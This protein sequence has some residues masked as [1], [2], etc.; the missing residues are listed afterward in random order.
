MHVFIHVWGAVKGNL[1]WL[2]EACFGDPVEN[3]TRDRIKDSL[4]CGNHPMPPLSLPS[5]LFGLG[6][7]WAAPGVPTLFSAL[8]RCPASSGM[9]KTENLLSLASGGPETSDCPLSTPW[10]AGFRDFSQPDTH[11]GP[12][13]KHARPEHPTSGG[14]QVFSHSLYSPT[15][16]AVHTCQ[17]MYM[18][19]LEINFGYRFQEFS[20]LPLRKG[21]LLAWRSVIEL[22]SMASEP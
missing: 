20:R 5:L 4:L 10:W 6:A 16:T 2:N 18:W 19:R 9:P 3:S 21:V 14:T 11:P 17:C 7:D 1:F 12:C 8:L 15:P 13:G 22:D